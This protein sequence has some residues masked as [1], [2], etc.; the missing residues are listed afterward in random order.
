VTVI[1]VPEQHPI[2]TLPIGPGPMDLALTPSGKYLYVTC[3]LDNSIV[4]VDTD[5]Q[6]IVHRI[7]L[8][9]SPWGIAF[10]PDGSRAFVAN[11]EYNGSEHS[12]GITGPQIN[13][14]TSAS[15]QVNNNTLLVINTGKYH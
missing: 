2:L 13:L 11:Y 8:D 6:R 12:Q 3:H 4:I 15:H 1:Y 7:E 14:G 5:S 9:V 10:S